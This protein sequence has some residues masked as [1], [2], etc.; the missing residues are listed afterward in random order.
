M[1]LPKIFEELHEIEKNS[2]CRRRYMPGMPPR[3]A[4]VLLRGNF[5]NVTTLVIL[6]KPR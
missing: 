2:G 4:N 6:G 3:F 1:I 5:R